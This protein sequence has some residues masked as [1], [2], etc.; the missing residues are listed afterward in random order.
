MMTNDSTIDNSELVCVVASTLQFLGTETAI[1]DYIYDLRNKYKKLVFVV[2]HPYNLGTYENP[3]TYDMITSMLYK[4]HGEFGVLSCKLN[5]KD[6]HDVT[7]IKNAYN[8]AYD[9]TNYTIVL[10]DTLTFG[11]MEK[12]EKVITTYKTDDKFQLGRRVG[13]AEVTKIGYPK[14]IMCVDVAILSSDNKTIWLGKRNSESKYRFIGGH[15]DS[16]KDL[17]LEE[18]AKRELMEEAGSFESSPME[19]VVGIMINDPRYSTSRDNIYS[20]LYK[21]NIVFGTP[22]AGDDINEIKEFDIDILLSP[23][24]YFVKEHIQLAKELKNYLIKT[25]EKEKK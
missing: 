3:L 16:G 20:V 21:T 9:N 22:N 18:A 23:D 4:K 19:Y 25:K 5:H 17:K 14:T 24:L 12:L 13:A 7:L 10:L 1:N 2:L 6:I 15:V 11:K 8:M